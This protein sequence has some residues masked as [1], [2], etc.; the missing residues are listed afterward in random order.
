M[1]S[2]KIVIEMRN[3]SKRFG[4]FY[5]NKNINFCLKEGEIHALLG[6]NGA[7]KS[8]MMNLLSGLLEPTSGQIY[9]NGQAVKID[10]PAK[11]SE[12]KIGMVHQHFMLIQDF[13]VVENIILGEE[14]TSG[15]VLDKKSARERVIEL[16][17][18][19][20]LKI[21]P[22]AKI[23]DISVGMQQRVEILKALYRHA[24]I[25]IFDEPTS[26]VD[27]AS[28]RHFAKSLE[29]LNKNF[30]VSIILITHELDWVKNNLQM[31]KFYEL[32]KGGLELVT[33]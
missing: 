8:T 12:L 1:A 20:G 21:D 28:K 2:D 16:S 25:L 26:G 32:K 4:D 15:V 30:D 7:G 13:T 19:Y 3:V 18:Q 6:E 24:E 33:V 27:E 14:P 29:D 10:S 17:N 11:A 22:D 23:E 5:A 31:D 9:L